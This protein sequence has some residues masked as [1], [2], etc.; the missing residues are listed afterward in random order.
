MYF[1]ILSE[2]ASGALTYLLADASAREAVLIDPR[3]DD[4]PVLQALLLERELRLCW[5]LRTHHHDD[6]QKGEF[7]ALQRL[8]A[9][10]VQGDGARGTSGAMPMAV[11]PFGREY[12]RVTPTP[13]HTAHCLSF[14]WRDRLFCGGLLAVDACPHQRQP[15]KPETLWDSVM[16]KVFTLPDETLV[17]PGYAR[18]GRVVTTV[19]EQ[20]HWHPFFAA[21]TRDAF[22]TRMRAPT[23]VDSPQSVF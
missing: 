8:G 22:L 10:L 23:T 6:V 5:I 16:R 20:R 15:Q 19:L 12:V 3:A 14:A 2:E 7:A 1:R 13:G 4:L 11:L 21:L 9:P 18:Q 17:F